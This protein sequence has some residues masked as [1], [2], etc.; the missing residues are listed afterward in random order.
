MFNHVLTNKN[1][2][3]HHYTCIGL[4]ELVSHPKPFISFTQQ[5]SVDSV[6]GPGQALRCMDPPCR[7]LAA[8]WAMTLML[9]EDENFKQKRAGAERA[10]G[11]GG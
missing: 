5:I 7:R 4:G 11:C 6:P 8:E 2:L 1:I 10:A 9:D 3:T